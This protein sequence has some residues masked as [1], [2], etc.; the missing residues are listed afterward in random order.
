MAKEVTNMNANDLK[1]ALLAKSAAAKAPRAPGEI[2]QLPVEL[3]LALVQK[4]VKSTRK[5]V[6]DMDEPV[7]DKIVQEDPRES[8]ETLGA[9]GMGD[10]LLAQANVPAS[11]AGNK[12]EITAPV[13][14]SSVS[15]GMLWGVLGAGALVA[16]ASGGGGSSG[17]A[18]APAPAP[19]PATF[20]VTEAG[21]VVNFDGTA[22]GEIT[23]SLTS[24]VATFTRGGVTATT[25][26][27]TL[28]DNTINLKSGQTV[29]LTGAQADT[30]SVEGVHFT[31]TG[32]V[33]IDANDVAGHTTRE[34][35]VNVDIT[36]NLT[37]DMTDASDKI[38]LAAN[39]VIN[40]HGGNLIVSDG[41]VVGFDSSVTFSNIGTI[42]LNSELKMT[43]AQFQSLGGQMTTGGPGILT[44]VVA[45]E[46]EAETFL[47][48]LV[49]HQGAY[50]ATPPAVLMD[51]LSVV[52][53]EP[54][55]VDLSNALQYKWDQ[56]VE[57]I[58]GAIADLVGGA[59]D[60][61]NTLGKLEGLITTL[62]GLV[63]DNHLAQTDALG[64]VQDALNVAIAAVADNLAAEAVLRL[65]GDA[66][67][68][69]SI[70]LVA[71]DLVT[72]QALVESNHTAQNDAVTAAI[73]AAQAALDTALTDVAANLAAEAALRLAGD[74]TSLTAINLVAADLATLQAL[75]DSNDLAQSTAVTNAIAA[76]DLALST[77]IDGIESRLYALEHPQ[78]PADWAVAHE[79]LDLRANEIFQ[80][81]YVDNTVIVGYTAPEGALDF[82][83]ETPVPVLLSDMDSQGHFVV[84]VG[85]ELLTISALFSIFTEISGLSSQDAQTVANNALLH[86][87]DVFDSSGADVFH[88]SNEGPLGLATEASLRSIIDFSSSAPVSD[89]EFAAF[90][91]AVVLDQPS[92]LA[93]D[94]AFLAQFHGYDTSTVELH[95]STALT[96]GQ[97]TALAEA[98]FNMPENVTYKIDDYFLNIQAAHNNPD[99]INLIEGA[100][101]A[102]MDETGTSMADFAIT[103]RGNELDNVMDFG[104][105]GH[106]LPLLVLAGAGNDTINAG[107]GDDVIVGQSG[108]DRIALTTSDFG[109]DTVV[110]A[111]AE[112]GA[113]YTVA[114]V[115]G[116][117][118]N[119]ADYREG[120]FLEVYINDTWVNYTITSADVAGEYTEQLVLQHLAAAIV[121]NTNLDIGGDQISVVDGQIRIHSEGFGAAASTEWLDVSN[122]SLNVGAVYTVAFSSDDANYYNDGHGDNFIQLAFT[123]SSNDSLP[124]RVFTQEMIGAADSDD[125]TQVYAGEDSVRFHFQP[126]GSGYDVGDVVNLHWSYA[127]LDHNETI[128]VSD[129][130]TN[131]DALG[132]AFE[133][134]I[135][136]TISDLGILG[137]DLSVAYNASTDEITVHSNSYSSFFAGSADV[138]N[139]D[140]YN[141]EL[142][143]DALRAQINTALSGEYA[144]TGTGTTVTIAAIGSHSYLDG[145][146]ISN[147]SITLTSDDVVSINTSTSASDEVLNFDGTDSHTAVHFSSNASNYIA[148]AT[149]QLK[150]AGADGIDNTSDDVAVQY[151]VT[152]DDVASGSVVDTILGNLV[153]A[154]NAD[155][156]LTGIFGAT[157]SASEDTITL[158]NNNVGTTEIHVVGEDSFGG[159]ATGV[160]SEGLAQ[161]YES[162][163][164]W[165]GSSSLYADGSNSMAL[166]FTIGI[167][168]Y[169]FS[170]DIQAGE[171]AIQAVQHFVDQLMTGL[172]SV[173][174]L[175]LGMTVSVL[176]SSTDLDILRTTMTLTGNVDGT[177]LLNLDLSGIYNAAVL[178]DGSI[179][180]T[181]NNS[182]VMDIASSALV[183]SPIA[184]D[185]AITA[186][187]AV[188]QVTDIDFGSI[189]AFHGAHIGV[190]IGSEDYNVELVYS[191][192]T[193][194]IHATLAALV[195]AINV[196]DID[197]AVTASYSDDTLTLTGAITDLSVDVGVDFTATGYAT[198]RD[199]FS[200]SADMTVIDGVHQYSNLFD[201][202]NSGS[203]D[204]RLLINDTGHSTAHDVVTGFQTG[205]DTIAFDGTLRASM[206]NRNNDVIDFHDVYSGSGDVELDFTGL[207][208]VSRTM[209]RGASDVGDGDANTSVTT[210]TMTDATHVAALLNELYNFGSG[211]DGVLNTTAFS[212]TSSN[213]PTNSAL[214]VHTQSYDG[215]H[216]IDASE[217]SLL[218]TIQTTGSEI[219]SYDFS[220]T[221][222]FP[223]TLYA[224]V[225][226]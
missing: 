97:A 152:S 49:Q 77:A 207:V 216:T 203:A 36:G 62:N 196:V 30:V 222:L 137:E 154:I 218:A 31:G 176:G 66:A 69:A 191:G 76:A 80:H 73:A 108:A 44:V 190:T 6:S 192:D 114:T 123:S 142:T 83:S 172:D 128:T 135:N 121:A 16:A 186:V 158:T 174:F 125:V 37:F 78:Q 90:L 100:T 89:S 19:A 95:V 184:G 42:T 40:L 205:N 185:A 93:F 122:A 170:Y 15:S 119:D 87:G 131:V 64:V 34:I 124:D 98:G 59:S 149:V 150:W 103:A 134:K 201:S 99:Q 126:V 147:H 20:V 94:T 214:W 39:S 136:S 115:A 3:D 29:V 217:L 155:A 81:A 178:L 58:N 70:N 106:D 101:S 133:T 177:P 209:N 160:F 51:I 193:V 110:Y 54:I 23:M 202:L 173:A 143:V 211:I 221:D 107:K 14:A 132:A 148:G 17:S 179:A 220:Y 25:T 104:N 197:Q 187:A 199:T 18:P 169:S 168:N 111:T 5:I 56:M 53:H 120:G 24:N 38:T 206:G 43:F 163:L 194:D 55:T 2:A 145:Y 129:A 109:A 189:D 161:A 10:V 188:A 12:V 13:A 156:A 85:S 8:T 208:M 138:T 46:A 210:T 35:A 140:V 102:S 153:T 200:G 52:N 4:S 48:Y 139:A 33:K 47:Q 183:D 226:V 32:N 50:G 215:D 112:D 117:T 213:S 162:N 105:F 41:V 79:P 175:A 28:N 86:P 67:N 195:N 157:Y 57:Q 84:P 164:T 63:D 141:A 165:A 212:I 26:V 167:S 223:K 182:G 61:A 72:L 11:P 9:S 91:S 22:T 198:G 151:T 68:L 65:D 74:E 224:T 127:G 21:A 181:N 88:F 75:V 180:L 27:T 96:V 45:D 144:V 82:S 166:K 60:A 204:S 146:S 219:G 225:P 159:I 118:G 171:T 1:N 71:A 116:Y 92:T 7:Q 113:S 130:T